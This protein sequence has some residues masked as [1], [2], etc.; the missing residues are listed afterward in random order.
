MYSKARGV[1]CKQQKLLVLKP[2]MYHSQAIRIRTHRGESIWS[3]LKNYINKIDVN[4]I[5]NRTELLSCV[6]VHEVVVG[7]IT[8]CATTVDQ[9]KRYLILAKVLESEN[10][11]TYKKL[12]NIPEHLSVNKLRDNV[13][14]HNWKTW[15]IRIEDL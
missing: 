12:R 10:W 9:Y 13:Y 7:G 2:G 14:A 3:L 5:F 4:T 6:Y 8:A 1:N 15:F 11:G